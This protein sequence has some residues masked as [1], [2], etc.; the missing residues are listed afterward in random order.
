[1]F[2]GKSVWHTLWNRLRFLL[3][4]GLWADRKHELV[5]KFCPYRGRNTGSK[6]FC[7]HWKNVEENGSVCRKEY[8]PFWKEWFRIS[9]VFGWRRKISRWI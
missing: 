8:C 3:F 7:S 5:K 1:M 6:T 4:V 9:G 2:C